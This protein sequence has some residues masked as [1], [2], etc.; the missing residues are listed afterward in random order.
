[1]E[2]LIVR[3]YELPKFDCD[4][5][6]CIPLDADTTS[7]PEQLFLKVAFDSIPVT[8]SSL[9]FGSKRLL[10]VDHP[11]VLPIGVPLKALVTSGDVLHS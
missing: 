11:L 3:N 1:M 5:E 4:G 7:S 9:N 10:E 6:R 2:A 8:E